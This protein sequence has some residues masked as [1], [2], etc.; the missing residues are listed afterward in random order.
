MR[1]P[2]PGSEAGWDCRVLRRD[3]SYF[4]SWHRFL[5]TPLSVSTPNLSFSQTF[6]HE[7]SCSVSLGAC[8]RYDLQALPD[9]DYDY[10]LPDDGVQCRVNAVLL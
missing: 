9:Y 7:C 2:H 4:S 3:R 1:H 6:V 8:G 5:L 10:G